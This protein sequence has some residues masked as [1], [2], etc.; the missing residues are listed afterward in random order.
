MMQSVALLV[1]CFLERER[2]A[3]ERGKGARDRQC[4]SNLCLCWSAHGTSCCV[5]NQTPYCSSLAWDG[6]AE[7]PGADRCPSHLAKSRTSSSSRRRNRKHT[8]GSQ[9]DW[10]HPKLPANSWGQAHRKD[11][12]QPQLPQNKQPVSH[13]SSHAHG[14]KAIPAPN[15]QQAHSKLLRCCCWRPS[16]PAHLRTIVTCD[17]RREGNTHEAERLSCR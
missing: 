11:P 2:G 10:R 1:S 14:Q 16:I 17:P 7:A 15:S 5:Y 8:R 13:A 9:V 3:R 4:S 6:R 12:A